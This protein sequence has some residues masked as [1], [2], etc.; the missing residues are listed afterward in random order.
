MLCERRISLNNGFWF[1]PNFHLT[2]E[3]EYLIIQ[4]S[5]RT[6]RFLTAQVSDCHENE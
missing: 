1:F 4:Y 3:I 6:Q 5:A 2:M